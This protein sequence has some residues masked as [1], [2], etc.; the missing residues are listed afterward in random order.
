M[1]IIGGATATGKTALAAKVAKSVGGEI[2]SAD[3]MQIYK[4]MDIGT[5]KVRDEEL[6]VVQHLIDIVNPKHNFT[7]VDYKNNAKKAIDE[8]RSRGKVPIITGGTGFYISSIIFKMDF[9]GNFSDAET[10]QTLEQELLTYGKDYLHGKLSKIDP[11]SADKIHPNNTKRLLR[12][13]EIS[14]VSGKPFSAQNSEMK[15]IDEK[16]IMYSLIGADREISGEKIDRRVDNMILNG[17]KAEVEGLI[18]NGVGFECQSMQ[19]IGYKEWKDFFN[20]IN[21]NVNDVNR[22]IKK[23][24]RAY[25][26][27]QETWFR[28]QYGEYNNIISVDKNIDELAEQISES[29]FKKGHINK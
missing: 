3:S 14:I 19:G 21:V 23:N 12:A 6:G 26:K 20:D 22:L 10:R 8:V 25:A 15:K 5:A 27:R 18:N 9:G 24:T 4:G 29:Y 13:L 7:V 17:L 1:I 11:V 16:F 2:I 28:G